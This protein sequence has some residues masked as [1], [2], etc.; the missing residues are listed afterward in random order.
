MTI[1]WLLLLPLGVA[2]LA[3]VLRRL[4]FVSA[5]LVMAALV[6]MASLCWMQEQPQSLLILG[7]SLTLSR[8]DATLLGFCYVLLAC[9]MLYYYPMLE[10][11]YAYPLALASMGVFTAAIIT[12]NTAIAGLLLQIGIVLVVMLIPSKRSAS[13]L[14]G[15]RALLLLALA[16]PLMLLA[17]WIM[18]NHL[19]IPSDILSSRIVGI[20]FIAGFGLA[21]GVIPFHVWLPPIFRHSSVFSGV[22]VSAILSIVLLARLRGMLQLA[23]WPG[24]PGFL[25]STLLYGGLLTAIVGGALTLVQ[26]PLSRVLA[27]A[28]VADL[29]LVLIGLGMGTITSIRMALLHALFRSLAI[30]TMSMALGIFRHTLGGEDAEHLAGSLRRAP[31]AVLGMTVGGLSLAGW[32]LTAGFASRYPLYSLLAA[33]NTQWFA[34]VAL[35]G[36]GP[37]WA[38][39]RCIVTALTSSPVSGS[40]REPLVPALLTLVAALVL[41]LA[42]VFPQL[43]LQ[44]LMR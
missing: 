17:Y 39:V 40:S 15:M 27:Y 3:F 18:E 7:R 24:D 23:M 26:R 5:P 32:P 35:C 21:L 12:R 41:L 42:G 29:G 28:A 2:P 37:A 36:I 8:Q 34:A 11:P 19:A 9:V 14:S 1:P 38:V 16:G 20:T 44:I 10:S 30:I 6:S 31:L 25:P 22:M 43:G 33:Y 4:R 13:A